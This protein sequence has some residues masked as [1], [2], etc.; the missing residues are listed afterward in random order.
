[1]N[2]RE[3]AKGHQEAKE[4][5]PPCV[6]PL[7]VK[8][9]RHLDNHRVDHE[10][11]YCPQ[12]KLLGALSV[13]QSMVREAVESLKRKEGGVGSQDCTEMREPCRE[14]RRRRQPR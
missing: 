7:R 12:I 11:E 13:T 6:V 4:K 3:D 14:K 10:A 1:V 2:G 9:R 8:V 5:E